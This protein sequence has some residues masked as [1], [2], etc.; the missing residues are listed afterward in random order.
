MC[1]LWGTSWAFISQKTKFFVIVAAETSD[2]TT[3]VPLNRIYTNW[4]HFGSFRPP[5]LRVFRYSPRCPGL[6][7]SCDH[8]SKHF[9]NDVISP[10]SNSQFRGKKYILSE[11]HSVSI[12]TR[13]LCYRQH[14][15]SCCWSRVKLAS[16]KKMAVPR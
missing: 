3:V 14:R 10:S 8:N 11:P 5:S 13:I 12:S 15:S 9:R 2:L 4:Y 6:A 16:I 7:P 1:F